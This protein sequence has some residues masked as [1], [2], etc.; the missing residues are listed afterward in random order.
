MEQYTYQVIEDNGGGLTLVIF[1]A[2]DKVVYLH[3]GY[4]YNSKPGQLQADIEALK[5]GDNPVTDWDGNEEDPQ[6]MYDNI[7]SYEYGWKVVADD[8]GIYPD[9]MGAAASREY[10]IKD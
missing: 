9:K 10:G 7:T 1:D 4:E 2:Q 3:S 8:K 5:H 6:A